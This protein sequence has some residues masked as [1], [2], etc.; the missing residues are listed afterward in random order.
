MAV[1][2]NYP[3]LEV[4]VVVKG[5][6]LHEYNGDEEE[7]SPEVTRYVEV[8]SGAS[9]AIR[10]TIPSA[11]FAEH[12]VRA[13][14]EIDGAQMRRSPYSNKRPRPEGVTVTHDT[15]A[16]RVNGIDMG[17]NF[18]FLEMRLSRFDHSTKQAIF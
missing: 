11:L 9:F 15:S 2:P 18:Q 6:A 3:E 1:H 10:Y 12:S 13:V 17:Q 4:K 16:A 14:I 5:E 8:S 7:E